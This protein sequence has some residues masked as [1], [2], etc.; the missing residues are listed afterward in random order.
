[1]DFM[2][3]RRREFDTTLRVLQAFPEDQKQLKPA[4]KSRTAAELATTLAMEERVITALLTTGA[5]TP[6]ALAGERPESMAAI[7][8]MWQ[9]SAADNN[10]NIEKLAPEELDRSVDFYGH[11]I[12]LRDALWAELLDHIHHRGQFSVYLRIAGARVPS[13]YGPTADM[14][15]PQPTA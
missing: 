10:G 7:I 2:T 12:A 14:P 6:N 1:M 3:L 5:I 13:I 9:Q 8:A 15:W 11:Q 4:D